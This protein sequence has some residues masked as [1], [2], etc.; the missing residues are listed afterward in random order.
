LTAEDLRSEFVPM[1]QELR[2]GF[3]RLV[4]LLFW[5]LHG[6]DLRDS[7]V[8]LHWHLAR[9]QEL[10]RAWTTIGNRIGKKIKSIAANLDG[11][12]QRRCC[13]RTQC[14]LL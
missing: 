9:A 10:L 4:G 8:A 14:E 6:R 1:K 7:G 12:L 2:D 3:E 11:T 5:R 13:T